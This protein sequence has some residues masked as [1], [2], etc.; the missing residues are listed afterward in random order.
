MVQETSRGAC[1]HRLDVH[2]ARR[3]VP[4]LGKTVL[5][6]YGKLVTG[7]ER[8]LS[9]ESHSWKSDYL[10]LALVVLVVAVSGIVSMLERRAC[11][12]SA[13][14]SDLSTLRKR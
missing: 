8:P 10:R 6:V 13:R 1:A 14:T 12:N 4:K 9:H 11:I 2:A 5:H 3:N 7:L